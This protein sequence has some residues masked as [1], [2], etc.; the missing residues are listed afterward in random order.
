MDPLA[1]IAG[2]GLV[3]LLV[4]ELLGEGLGFVGGLDELRIVA[5]AEV[6]VADLEGVG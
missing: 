1:R 5:A 3:D 4:E 6:T 2:L